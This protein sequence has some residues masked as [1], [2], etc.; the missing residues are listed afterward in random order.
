[1]INFL[2]LNLFLSTVFY[3][4]LFNF[5]PNAVEFSPISLNHIDAACI[6]YSKAAWRDKRLSKAV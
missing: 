6:S 2:L 5:L 3:S 4:R 1:M